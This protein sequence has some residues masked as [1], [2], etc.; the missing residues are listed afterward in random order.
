M[1]S[2]SGDDIIGF[3]S[4]LKKDDR[5]CSLGLSLSLPSK[6]FESQQQGGDTMAKTT[7]HGIGIPA[8]GRVPLSTPG[9]E[10]SALGLLPPLC[11][12]LSHF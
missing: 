1:T 9:W 4:T 2:L 3:H 12:E 5:M 7:Q 6:L 11:M 8:A 10:G